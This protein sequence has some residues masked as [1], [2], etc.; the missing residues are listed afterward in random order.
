MNKKN[1]KSINRR[2]KIT[3]L[4]IMIIMSISFLYSNFMKN[5][6]IDQYNLSMKINIK[7]SDLSVSLNDSWINFD[8]YIKFHEAD[9]Y[10]KFFEANRRIDGIIKEVAPYVN[11]DKN[12]S[13]YLRTLTN[14]YEI[15]REQTALIMAREK[16]DVETYEQ[17]VKLGRMNFYISQHSR[18]LTSAY[19]Q[20]T[21]SYYSERLDKYKTLDTNLYLLLIS[22]I[23]FSGFLIWVV[24]H[25]IIQTINKLSM[26]VKQLSDSNWNIPD[27]EEQTYKELDNLTK[28][29]NHM[30]NKLRNYITALNEKAEIEKNYHL[31]KLKSAEKDK[32]IKDTQLKALQMQINPHF[33][34]NNLNTVSRMAM[35]EEADKTVDLIGALSKILRY[36]LISTDKLVSL[37][38][39]IENV[40]AYVLIQKTKFEDRVSFKF[41]INK[42]IEHIQIPPMIIQLLVE[43]AI[44]HG[45]SGLDRE[46]IIKIDGYEKDGFGIITV[47]DNGRGILTD[48]EKAKEIKT[49]TGLGLPNIKKR[50]ELYYSRNDLLV[51]E[52]IRGEGCKVSV[53]I[54][55]REGESVAED[56]GS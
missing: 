2:I 8:S 47:Q 34:F 35:F 41:N 32:L 3:F 39:E 56:Y 18:N 13:I 42:E 54:P 1:N 17:Y 20:F 55:I 37:K 50:L 27:I 5:N 28:T 51:I 10:K 38:E 16:L 46:G 21:D 43:N 22:S 52:S 29:F 30:K 53:L 26:S 7:L 45:F 24:N 49:T 44:I 33:L 31:E 11:E 36:N 9:A 15:Y 23:L 4:L 19:L 25:D 40:K 48:C 6:I 14:M 12:S